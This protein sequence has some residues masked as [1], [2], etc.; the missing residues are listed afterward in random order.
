M[1]LFSGIYCLLS[2]SLLLCLDCARI[3]PDSCI[4]QAQSCAG[5]RN[6]ALIALQVACSIRLGPVQP[7]PSAPTRP[8]MG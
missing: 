5:W 2:T 3:H 6:F 4:V 7:T 1:M 8:Q